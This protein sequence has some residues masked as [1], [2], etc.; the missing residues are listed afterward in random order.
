VLSHAA[1][2]VVASDHTSLQRWALK[3]HV[4]CGPGPHLL[5]EVI[6]GAATW[7][8]ALDLVSLLS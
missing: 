6:F 2:Q 8:V 5:A 4:S 3:H 1:T 7:R